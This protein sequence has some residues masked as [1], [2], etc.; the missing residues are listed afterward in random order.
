MIR[1]KF[2]EKYL[3]KSHR[4]QNWDYSWNGYYFVTICT[5]DRE[6]F[7]GKIEKEKM[8]LNHIGE[9]VEKFWLEIPKHFENVSL[10]EFVIM[11][12]HIHGIIIIDNLVSTG[13]ANPV[14]TQQHNHVETQ[15]CCVS[16]GN[17][18]KSN[19]FYKL[20]P[21][22]LPVIIRSYKSICTKTINH[23]QNEIFFAWQPRFY[24]H[25]I[26]NENSLNRIREYIIHNPLKWDL[27]KNNKA[28]IN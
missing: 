27:D 6:N 9:M 23:V 13:N 17:T 4:L 18:K 10:D 1:E 12:N 5:K 21:K 14:E 16:T 26:R 11:P 28:V 7:F 2:Q 25:V 15:Q 8:S 20:K 19:T 3:A 24:D 22:S